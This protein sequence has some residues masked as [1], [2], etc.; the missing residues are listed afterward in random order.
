MNLIPWDPWEELDRV[1][2]R[3]ERLWDEFLGKIA[4]G[5][6]TRLAFVPSADVVESPA[7]YRLFVAVPGFVEE[8]IEITVVDRA[9]VV[10]GE[11]LPPYD[12]ESATRRV[13]EMRYGFFERRFELVEP[14]DAE[15]LRAHY[16]AGVLTIV[17]SKAGVLN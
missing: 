12:A 3:T 9:L 8:D 1:R 2:E 14:I 17:V 5:M 11:S 6:E 15:T 10:R 4:D 16:D 13:G 7:E